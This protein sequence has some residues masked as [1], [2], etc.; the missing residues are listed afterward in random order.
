MCV[1]LHTYIHTHIYIYIYL[2]YNI[3]LDDLHNLSP[4]VSISRGIQ[5]AL[6]DRSH[7]PSD[8]KRTSLGKK[9]CMGLSWGPIPRQDRKRN[10]D[11]I[12]PFGM[13]NE[14]SKTSMLCML[15]MQWGHI[16]GH[17]TPVS[18][19]LQGLHWVVVQIPVT[20]LLNIPK[21]GYIMVCHPFSSNSWICMDLSIL[22]HAYTHI[23]I[24]P[25]ISHESPI[26]GTIQVGITAAH[27][28]SPKHV[29]NPLAAADSPTCRTPR[30]SAWQQR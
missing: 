13:L 8:P 4:A 15:N 7:H 30:W 2:F 9:F 18:I 25:Y 10:H 19:P 12:L 3:Y 22:T 24:Y 26:I 21:Y 27:P 29:R 28:A 23:Y 14:P 11:M 16:T 5:W 20:E 6:L 1:R 17:I